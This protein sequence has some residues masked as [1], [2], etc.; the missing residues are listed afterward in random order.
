MNRPWTSISATLA[1][2]A[3]LGTT[4]GCARLGIG[5]NG[6]DPETESCGANL[7]GAMGNSMPTPEVKAYI[8]ARVGERPIRYYTEGDPITM[9]YNPARL[10][11]VLG[12][13]G[14]IQRFRCG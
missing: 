5:K 9:D 4:A 13:D 2:A 11:V 1:A 3:L 8:D 14:R 7:L 12:Q 10:N 6:P